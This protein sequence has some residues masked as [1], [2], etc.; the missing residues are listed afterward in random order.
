MGG[1]GRRADRGEADFAAPQGPVRRRGSEAAATGRRHELLAVNNEAEGVVL[2][3][4]HDDIGAGV[5][6]GFKSVAVEAVLQPADK[7]FTDEALK[8]IADKIVAAA[9]KQGAVLRS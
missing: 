4:A 5:D 9:A 1:A 6:E 2:P 8:A 3:G 7:S